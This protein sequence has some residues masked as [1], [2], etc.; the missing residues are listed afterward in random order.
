M[1]QE[2]SCSQVAELG[3]TR[4]HLPGLDRIGQRKSCCSSNGLKDGFGLKAPASG[5][6]AGKR[7]GL[8]SLI[9]ESWGAESTAIVHGGQ[10]PGPALAADEITH[11]LFSQPSQSRRC[12]CDERARF[13][14]V[15]PGGEGRSAV[16]LACAL[17]GGATCCCTQARHPLHAHM[18][19]THTVRLVGPRRAHASADQVH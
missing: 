12:P 15:V 13:F 5:R 4:R 1:E 14:L 16:V 3:D 10:I 8:E 19:K 6:R 11:L 7:N 2:A 17:R 18:P 9:Y